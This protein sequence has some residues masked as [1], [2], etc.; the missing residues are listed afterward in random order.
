ME[1]DVRNEVKTLVHKIDGFETAIVIKTNIDYERVADELKQ[2]KS[3][4]TALDNERKSATKPIDETKK[5]IMDWFRLPLERLA[6][7][8]AKRKSAMIAYQEEQ[9]RI[10]LAEEARLRKLQEAEAERIKA[11]ADKAL[12]K[13]NIGKA[14]ELQQQAQEVASIAPVVEKKT[15]DIAGQAIKLIW[16]YRI[17]DERLIPREYLTPDEQKIG[18]VIRATKGSLPIPG[19]QAYSEKSLSSG[20]A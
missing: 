19:I 2:I 13:G 5:K 9:E 8:E 14:E 12:E 7:A 4:S 17:V 3:L 20:R 10:R 1:V 16:K 15:P 11:K 18:Q 6:G